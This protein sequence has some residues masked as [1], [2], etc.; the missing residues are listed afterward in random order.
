MNSAIKGF[1][2]RRRSRTVES[3]NRPGSMDKKASKMQRL[4]SRSDSF[5]TLMRRRSTDWSSNGKYFPSFM[6]RRISEGELKSKEKKRSY[7]VEVLQSPKEKKVNQDDNNIHFGSEHL[8]ADGPRS[9]P[10]RSLSNPS[11]LNLA[12]EQMILFE[13]GEPSSGES[14]SNGNFKTIV[15]QNCTE[16]S[17]QDRKEISS[18]EKQRKGDTASNSGQVWVRRSRNSTENPDTSTPKE[19]DETLID[20][21][22]HS[23]SH[24]VQILLLPESDESFLS[25]SGNQTPS[26]RVRKISAPEYLMSY[27]TKDNQ[28][29]VNES[30]ETRETA[31]L[32][33]KANQ[34]SSEKEMQKCLVSIR[35]NQAVL[36]DNVEEFMDLLGEDGL[37]LN[38]P[39]KYG[40]TLLHKAAANGSSRCLEA[41]LTRSAPVNV[42]DKG[43]WT[44]LHHAVY[45]GH[46]RC[47]VLLIASGADAEAE[48][49][50]FVKPIELADKDEM[51]LLI[52][53]AM[54][55][56]DLLVNTNSDRETLV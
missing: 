15:R 47:A 4:R 38:H 30:R 1:E 6:F 52:G 40:L 12:K 41:L 19:L 50:D 28:L 3:D 11:L 32:Q 25:R 45:H 10:V 9:A 14:C 18:N 37:Q 43:G 22:S 53:R 46:V 26:R 34:N 2:F 48:T 49:C 24:G 31:T 55:Q 13:A 23:N 7:S 5:F 44:P 36:Y 16:E 20:N 8:S 27:Y 42:R 39:N 17:L 35:L 29:C 54:V 21:D 51:I 33:T 56:N